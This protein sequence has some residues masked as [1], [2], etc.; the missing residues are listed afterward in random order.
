MVQLFV[1]V[2]GRVIRTTIHVRIW[3]SKWYNYSYS[4][5]AEYGN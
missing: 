2:F 5:L 3:P 4:H 1:F